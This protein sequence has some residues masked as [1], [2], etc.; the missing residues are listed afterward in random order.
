MRAG[1]EKCCAL[2]ALERPATNAAD[3]VQGGVLHVTFLLTSSSTSAPASAST[4]SPPPRSLTTKRTGDNRGGH[5]MEAA[6][7]RP[8]GSLYGS[9]CRTGNTA[10]MPCASCPRSA[11]SNVAGSA[12]RLQLGINLVLAARQ[13]AVRPTS[14]GQLASCSVRTATR[15]PLTN[16]PCTGVR[17]SAATR[18]TYNRGTRRHAQVRLGAATDASGDTSCPRERGPALCP[19]RGAGPAGV[20]GPADASARP[21]H[22]AR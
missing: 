15:P 11:A 4:R 7:R 3:D 20:M 19:A 10:T 5:A 12:A 21:A 8:S 6:S 22:R 1:G 9:T 14:R 17:N 13:R 18:T 2:R 16:P